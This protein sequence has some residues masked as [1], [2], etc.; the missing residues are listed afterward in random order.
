MG[1]R[2]G[3]RRACLSQTGA[4]IDAGQSADAAALR[5]WAEE[6]GLAPARLIALSDVVGPGRFGVIRHVA[7]C[8]LAR[9]HAAFPAG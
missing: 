9:R 6:T 7:G 2:H 8:C 5:E 4:F 3:P 1:Y